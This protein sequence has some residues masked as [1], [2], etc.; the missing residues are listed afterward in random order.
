[1]QASG[2][3]FERGRPGELRLYGEPEAAAAL[4]MEAARRTGAVVHRLERGR[5][6]L[7][8]IFLRAVGG[9]RPTA[10]AGRVAEAG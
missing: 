4:A 6:S 2:A 8:D 10:G 9:D 5:N 3:R 7:E 1:L